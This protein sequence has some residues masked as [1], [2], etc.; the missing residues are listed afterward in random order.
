[1]NTGEPFPKWKRIDP[2]LYYTEFNRHRFDAMRLDDGMWVPGVDGKPLTEFWPGVDIKTRFPRL[3]AALEACVEATV[4]KHPP[5][6]RKGGT[7]CS[8]SVGYPA[9]HQ[10][11]HENY[12][13]GH[14]KEDVGS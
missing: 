12:W 2:G 8:F 9:G 4:P 3:D 10:C 13:I 7:Y 14:L 5:Q 11:G 1:M 6:I